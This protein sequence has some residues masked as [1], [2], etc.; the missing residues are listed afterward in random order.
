MKQSPDYNPLEKMQSSRKSKM[1]DW[2]RD[3]ISRFHFGKRISINPLG[4]MTYINFPPYV[5]ADRILIGP[6]GNYLNQKCIKWEF[7]ACLTDDKKPY[8]QIIIFK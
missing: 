3:E 2:L 8:L 6:I 1:I 7:Q 4:E 5:N